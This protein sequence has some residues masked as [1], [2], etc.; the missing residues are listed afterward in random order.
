MYPRERSATSKGFLSLAVAL[1]LTGA[2]RAEATEFTVTIKNTTAVAWTEGLITLSPTSSVG[3]TP[4]SGAGYKAYAYGSRGC[5]LDDVACPTGSCNDN[6]NAAVLAQRLGLT[7]GISAWIVPAL[8]AS[9]SA[10]V[11]ISATGAQRM[12]FL[13]AV[14]GGAGT[15]DDVVFMHAEGDATDLSVPLFNSSGL[16]IAPLAFELGGYDLASSDANDGT[17]ADC[18][19][20]CPAPGAGCYIAHGNG[21]TGATL[22]A[23]PAQPALS[24]AWT[25]SEPDHTTDGLALGDVTGGSANELVVLTE[26]GGYETPENQIVRGRARVLTGLNGIAPTA[27]SCFDPSSDG[28]DLMGFPLVENLTST[29]VPATGQ[30]DYIVQEFVDAEGEAAVHARHGESTT[31]QWTST[32]Y[33]YPGFWNMGASSGD[34]RTEEE[35]AGNEIVVPTWTGDLA[36]LKHDSGESLNA[37]SFYTAP[38]WENLYGHVT[39]AD[40]DNDGTNE[41]VA[42]GAATGTVYVLHTNGSAGFDIVWQSTPDQSVYAFGSGPAVAD[43]DGDGIKEIIVASAET[44]QVFAYDLTYDVGCK[45]SWSTPGAGGYYWT[46]PVVGD[47]D[48]DGT[49]DKEVVAFSSSGLLSV[50]G[51]P[52]APSIGCATGSVKWTHAVGNGDYAWFTP[53]LANLTGNG[54]LDIVVATYNTI[55]VVDA[56]A[57]ESVL[58]F[59]DATAAFYPSAVIEKRTGDASSPAASIYVSGWANGKVYKLNT[60]SSNPVPASDWPTFMGNNARTGAR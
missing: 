2:G 58:R 39:I 45:Y 37:F 16:P 55:E 25:Y 11:R 9:A 7:L 50:L 29:E 4:T 28:R 30:G 32:G 48:G 47:V 31:A 40:L 19:S 36:V 27:P 1:L 24:L 10:S 46:S 51:V 5:H 17:A 34:L 13:A 22:A 53:A 33:G 38:V 49:G 56:N 41:I 57:E 60:P 43:L 18:A 35:N 6:G 52:A 15:E 26:A 20:S 14:D 44:D 8:G 23:Q 42:F 54:A 21:S 12:S 3:A 59:S